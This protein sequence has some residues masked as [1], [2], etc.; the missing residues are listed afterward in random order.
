MT[1][2]EELLNS[3]FGTHSHKLEHFLQ[4]I[5]DQNDS[6]GSMYSEI[7]GILNWLND[8]TQ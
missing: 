1:K 6:T 2:L 8:E 4:I 7:E 5:A 3:Y